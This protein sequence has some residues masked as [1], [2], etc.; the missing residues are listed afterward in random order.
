MTR[1]LPIKGYEGR[2]VVS[3]TGLIM[4]VGKTK[5]NGNILLGTVDKD[6]Y[7]RVSLRKSSRDKSPKGF[8]VHRL[9]A[10]SFI[11]NP[12]NLPCINHKNENKADNRVENLEWCDVRYNDNYGTRNIRIAKN[13]D[14]SK[15][16]KKVA[17]IKEGK[18]IKIYPNARSA[19]LD[20]T[21]DERARFGIRTICN[22]SNPHAHT[23]YGFK[24][25]YI[26]EGGDR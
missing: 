22:G 13:R 7:R 16:Y 2:Y 19:A 18:I 20:T 21:G 14:W 24:W 4:N 6:G 15:A 23:A 26:A 5:R 12:R 17:K 1:W 8:A 11:P 3:D 25:R 9:V 10:L